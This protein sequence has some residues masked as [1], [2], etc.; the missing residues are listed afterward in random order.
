MSAHPK[1]SPEVRA[2]FERR[3]HDPRVMGPNLV[4]CKKCPVK[5][6]ASVYS[7]LAKQDCHQE[8]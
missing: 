2:A 7:L 8:E 6:T 4:G 1:L 5:G 3:S